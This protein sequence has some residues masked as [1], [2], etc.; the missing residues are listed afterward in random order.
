M[1]FFCPSVVLLFFPVVKKKKTEMQPASKRPKLSVLHGTLGKGTHGT[2]RATSDANFVV[3]CFQSSPKE[4]VSTECLREWSALERL[5]GHPNIVRL[6]GTSLHDDQVFLLLPM[7]QTDLSKFLVHTGALPVERSLYICWQ[8][9]QAL[10]ACSRVGL[11]HR[12]VKPANILLGPNDHAVLCD[13]GLARHTDSPGAFTNKVQ[14]LWYRA[15]EILL[16]STRYGPEIDIWSLGLILIEMLLGRTFLQ[17]RKPEDQLNKIFQV[18]GT[19]TLHDWPEVQQLPNFRGW[20]GIPAP[21]SFRQ[22]I[23][24]LQDWPAL[25]EF[26]VQVLCLNPANRARIETIVQDPLFAAFQAPSDSLPTSA[27]ARA[28]PLPSPERT[29]SLCDLAAIVIQRRWSWR[30]LFASID[31]FDLVRSDQDACLFIAAKMHE[32]TVI[33]PSHFKSEVLHDEVKI[34]RQINGRLENRET[35][36]AKLE[37]LLSPETVAQLFLDQLDGHSQDTLV[38]EITAATFGPAR[39]AILKRKR[40]PR[41]NAIVEG[42]VRG[43]PLRRRQPNDETTPVDLAIALLSVSAQDLQEDDDES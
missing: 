32:P 19:P 31:L 7:F 1:C 14:T 36:F 18:C 4:G 5:R 22:H 42:I 39:R 15:P 28:N 33:D 17:K 24:L 16:G 8:L 38:A 35:A 25:D 11:S 9:A 10:L 27:V 34:L 43:R 12:D 40:T 29:R 23:P 21:G 41:I 20:F 37:A 6:E 2:I 13:F 26:L 3:K 30:T